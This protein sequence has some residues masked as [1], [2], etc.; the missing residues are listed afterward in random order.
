MLP[1][2]Y[3]KKSV[4]TR[5][6]GLPLLLNV[7]QLTDLLGVSDSS[8]YELIQVPVINLSVISG[9]V[10]INPGSHRFSNSSSGPSASSD[11]A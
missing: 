11:N 7:K 8:V 9:M 6:D 1:S 3:L 2:W 10:N 5:Y 4:F